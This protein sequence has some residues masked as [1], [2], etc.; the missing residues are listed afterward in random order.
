MLTIQFPLLDVGTINNSL[1]IESS[2]RER[3]REREGEG[4]RKKEKREREGE[5]KRK[6][7]RTN[8]TNL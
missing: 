8:E 7:C 5:G 6:I 2:I 3:E 1:L 4:K